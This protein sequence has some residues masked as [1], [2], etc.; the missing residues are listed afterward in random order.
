[1]S[2]TDPLD[3][4]G[5]QQDREDDRTERLAKA[6]EVA[7]IAQ[8]KAKA[9]RRM[10]YWQLAAYLLIFSMSV[11]GWWQIEQ[12]SDARCDAGEA[13]R[14]ALRNI[15]IGVGDLGTE[16]VTQGQNPTTPE[17]EAALEDFADFEEKQLALIAGPVCPEE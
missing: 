4:N 3:E 12:E 2:F 7:A 17:Q 5:Y 9:H 14:A 16:L 15:I 13:N 8:E 1:M 11:I 10:A 6:E